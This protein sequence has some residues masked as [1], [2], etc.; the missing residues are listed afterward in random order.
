MKD[1]LNPPKV[2]KPLCFFA[3]EEHTTIKPQLVSMLPVLRG[4]KRRILN[5]TLRK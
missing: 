4:I 3:P 5:L 2:N 1:H